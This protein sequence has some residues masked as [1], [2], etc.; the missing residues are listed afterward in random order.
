MTTYLPKLSTTLPDFIDE[1]FNINDNGGFI[2]P[3]SELIDNFFSED[4]SF[5]KNY[6]VRYFEKLS[7]PKIDI[8]QKQ[9]KVIITAEIPGLKKEDIQLKLEENPVIDGHTIDN[10][11]K[12]SI[13]G[14]KQSKK[15][16]KDDLILVKE[17]K[18]SAFTRSILLVKDIVDVENYDATFENG[19]LEIT[20]KLL[21]PK[22]LEEKSK[23]KTLQ[24]K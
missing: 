5:R 11:I 6:G 24:I 22:P 4:P 12:L 14:S 13:C 21:N 9:D 3:F 23:T 18:Q 17:L 16:D 8:I 1:F 10:A 20:F 15:I 2:K 19:V 7:Y